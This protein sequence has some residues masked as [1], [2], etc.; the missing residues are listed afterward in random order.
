MQQDETLRLGGPRRRCDA[1][2]ECLLKAGQAHRHH[3]AGCRR[4]PPQTVAAHPRIHQNGGSGNTRPPPLRSSG[5]ATHQV[6]SVQWGMTALRS[7]TRPGGQVGPTLPGVGTKTHAL[8]RMCTDQRPHKT[9]RTLPSASYNR[10]RKQGR[11][12]AALD[13]SHADFTHVPECH[14]RLTPDQQ[15]R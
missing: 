14:D 12:D 15:E 5:T 3:D 8:S 2:Q 1:V 11:R 10:L 6:R 7:M 13:G 4:P 9:H